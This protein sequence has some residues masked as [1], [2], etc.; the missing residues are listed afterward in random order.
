MGKRRGVNVQ[1]AADLVVDELNRLIDSRPKRRLL[2]VAQLRGSASSVSAN[3]AEGLGRGEGDARN[4]KYRI[5]RG[6]AEET[7]SHLRSNFAAERIPRAVYY[8]LRNRSL[9]VIKMLD[10][11]LRE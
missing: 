1:E 8:R 7:I 3:I 10:S 11:L 4:D 6:E 2:D 5:A 9:T